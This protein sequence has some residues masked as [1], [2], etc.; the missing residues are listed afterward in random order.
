[1]ELAFPKDGVLVF[2]ATPQQLHTAIDL[3]NGKGESLASKTTPLTATLPQGVILMARAA[4]LTMDDVD[5][6][7]KLFRPI[8]GFEYIVGES[9]GHW[10]ESLH[11]RTHQESAARAMQQILSGKMAEAELLFAGHEDVIQALE[12]AKVK[13]EGTEVSVSF[14]S[15]AAKL[16]KLIPP[17]VEEW[18]EHW[19]QRATFFRR[20][21]GDTESPHSTSGKESK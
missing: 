1:V 10:Q 17:L 19:M 21:L 8:S 6:H 18:R 12:A 2:A 14:E 3:L 16:A 15:D 13:R 11:L 5:P 7:F 20:C 4:G 9:N